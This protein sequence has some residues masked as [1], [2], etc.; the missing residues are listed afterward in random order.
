MR[1]YG[2]EAIPRSLT[3]S[4]TCVAIEKMP[5]FYL[6]RMWYL[7]CFK[8]FIRFTNLYIIND[9]AQTQNEDVQP[10]QQK[11]RQNPHGIVRKDLHQA[12]ESRFEDLLDLKRCQIE[13]QIHINQPIFN[14][15]HR[16]TLKNQILDRETPIERELGQESNVEEEIIRTK[17]R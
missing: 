7:M 9:A 14:R 17:V 4:F 5:S 2:A 16:I 11:N 15:P 12:E 8:S 3:T 13:Q 1:I 10:R 6:E